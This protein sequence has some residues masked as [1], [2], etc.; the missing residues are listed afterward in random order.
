MKC[1]ASILL[2]LMCAFSCAGAP[3]VPVDDV[4]AVCGQ[5]VP[6]RTGERWAE[7]LRAA[8]GACDKDSGQLGLPKV[9]FDQFAEEVSEANYGMLIMP[10]GLANS[11]DWRRLEKQLT[12]SEHVVQFEALPI[13]SG[14]SAVFY[15]C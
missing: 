13:G 10:N 4:A 7:I 6:V 12:N 3:S 11:I 14:F 5:I 8:N 2:G 9:T 15:I 1:F